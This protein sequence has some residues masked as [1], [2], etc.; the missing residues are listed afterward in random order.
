[1]LHTRNFSRQGR[2]A[3]QQRDNTKGEKTYLEA[4]KDEDQSEEGTGTEDAGNN[5]EVEGKNESDREKDRRDGESQDTRVHLNE[6][7]DSNEE[8]IKRQEEDKIRMLEI[9]TKIVISNR[10]HEDLLQTIGQHSR[11]MK[12]MINKQE[13]TDKRIQNLESKTEETTGM[14]KYVVDWIEQ[15]ARSGEDIMKMY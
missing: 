9:G 6:I 2:E 15:G 12:N 11:M 7:M 14:L 4:A 1:M 5:M 3:P 10:K 8:M 13:T